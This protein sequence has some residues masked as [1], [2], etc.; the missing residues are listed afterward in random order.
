MQVQLRATGWQ[1]EERAAAVACRCRAIVEK[2]PH[3]LQIHKS[4]HSF[5]PRANLPNML[6]VKTGSNSKIS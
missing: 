2:Q 3:N 1:S 5:G 6:V 4:V